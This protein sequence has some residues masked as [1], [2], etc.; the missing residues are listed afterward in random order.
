MVGM[1]QRV[2]LRKFRFL[3]I[4]SE[5][6]RTLVQNARES[7][8]TLAIG[9]HIRLVGQFFYDAW[10]MPNTL[11]KLRADAGGGRGEGRC[12]GTLWEIHPVLSVT[13]L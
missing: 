6:P 3:Y 5:R 2:L 7:G 13:R 12:A 8:S 11:A 9:D 10:H 4:P 1:I